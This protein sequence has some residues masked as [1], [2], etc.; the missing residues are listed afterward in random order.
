MSEEKTLLK[1]SVVLKKKKICFEFE[2][3]K[4]CIDEIVKL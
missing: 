4:T 1:E 2:T 3:K